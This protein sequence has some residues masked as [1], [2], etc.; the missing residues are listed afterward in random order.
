MWILWAA[1]SWGADIEGTFERSTPSSEISAAVEA[2]VEASIADLPGMARGRARGQ[3]T[4]KATTCSNYAFRHTEAELA[5]RCDGAA[6]VVVPVAQLGVQTTLQI[7]GQAVPATVTHQGDVIEAVFAGEEGS[8]TIRFTF[9]A[10][11][12]TVDNT[13][14][15]SKLSVPLMW[16]ASYARQ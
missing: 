3:L 8:R 10:G 1:L 5:W 9:A 6:E 12:L 15:G 14:A 13:L 7:D 2:A 11:Q 4:D 16:S